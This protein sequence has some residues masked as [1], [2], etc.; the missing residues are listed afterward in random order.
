MWSILIA[1][2]VGG[3]AVPEQADQ[4]EAR[5]AIEARFQRIDRDRNGFIT[6]NEAPRIASAGASQ[7]QAVPA[8]APWIETY[9]SDGDARISPAEFLARSLAGRATAGLARR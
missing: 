1:A 9:D 2:A 7:P 4:G 6:A 3:A 8:T 5:A